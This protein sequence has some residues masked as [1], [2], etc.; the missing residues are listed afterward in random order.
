MDKLLPRKIILAH[1]WLR[2]AN[3]GFRE[4]SIEACRDSGNAKEIS[5]IELDLRKSNDG[6][7]Y[8]YHGNFFEYFIS[9]RFE[10][11]FEST[12]K[13]YGV[14]KLSE[15]LDVISEWK[16]VFLDI[17]DKNITKED[18]LTAFGG[19]NF[20]RVM[21]GNKSV[22]FLDRFDDMSSGFVK[23]LNGNLLCY[24]YD[25][26]KLHERGFRY[27]EAVF[28]FQVSKNLIER[29]EKAGLEFRV[30]GLFFRSKNHYWE[31]VNFYGLHH[32]SSDFISWE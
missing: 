28:P 32:I 13:R 26:K 15:L 25:F 11:T 4:H 19:R 3:A 16:T 9:L 17:K 22:S 21:L 6:V 1:R 23:I 29:A 7:L 12:R 27:V 2:S 8:C 31:I 24:F 10:K 5:I 30:A 14:F 18:I 20:E